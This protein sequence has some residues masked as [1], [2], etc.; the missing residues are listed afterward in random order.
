MGLGKTLGEW[1]RG[2]RMTGR[3]DNSRGK[4]G[5]AKP[6]PSCRHTV[7][8]GVPLESADGCQMVPP[9]LHIL[10]LCCPHPKAQGPEA[11]GVRFSQLCWLLMG[12]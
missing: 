3:Q 6:P 2:D 7:A 11:R 5:Q 1:G 9:G 10:Q 12:S 4:E 8:P